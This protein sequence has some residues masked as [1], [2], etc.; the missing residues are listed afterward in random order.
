MALFGGIIG[1][2]IGRRRGRIKTEKRLMPVQKKLK[3]RLVKSSYLKKVNS[4][5]ANMPAKRPGKNILNSIRREP[6]ARSTGAS[7]VR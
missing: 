2:L 1:Y 6:E 3:N 7:I 5:F 4:V